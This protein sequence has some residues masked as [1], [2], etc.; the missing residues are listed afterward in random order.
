MR[1]LTV[2]EGRLRQE[3]ARLRILLRAV[4]KIVPIDLKERIE[5]ELKDEPEDR[6]RT[7]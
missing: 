5:A 1:K 6:Q 2:L 3:N 7:A 4:K